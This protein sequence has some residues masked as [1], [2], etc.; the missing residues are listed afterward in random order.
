[1]ID[2]AE[3]SD[4]CAVCRFDG[5]HYTDSDV[6]ATLR[7]FGTRWEWAVAGVPSELLN[8]H[9]PGE[10]AVADL[11]TLG[12][13]AVH[14]IDEGADRPTRRRT[15]HLAGHVLHLAGRRLRDVGAA[16][17]RATGHVGG[18]FAS[19]G[20]V[21]KRP[22]DLARVTYRG[23][24]GDRQAERRHHGRVWQALC[25]FS[26]DVI[27]A[28]QR[29]GHPI[30]PG[31]AGE[32]VSIR[33][34]DWIAVRPG[35]QIRIGTVLAEVTAY[36]TPCKKNA[37]WFVDRQFSRINHERHPGWSRTYAAVLEDGEVRL[38]DQVVLE[39]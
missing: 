21:P 12:H 35:A 38:G 29:E 23:V 10:T 8:G 25:L 31:R 39:P 4:P 1:M 7:T 17:A 32:N 22:I 37:G 3:L 9:R 27:D 26:G 30:A 5:D 34:V 2:P 28:L 36:A 11:G 15:A 6:D 18:L 14:A 33:G 13:D 20:G 24:E 16:P 19:D